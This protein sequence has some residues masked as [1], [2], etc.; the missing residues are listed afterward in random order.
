MKQFRCQIDLPI[1]KEKREREKQAL[2]RLE[3]LVIRTNVDT[4]FPFFRSFVRSFIFFFYFSHCFYEEMKKRKN[5]GNVV[6]TGT[7]RMNRER[8]NNDAIRN[9]IRLKEMKKNKETISFSR[10]TWGRDEHRNHRQPS[11]TASST[12]GVKCL[13]GRQQQ[14]QR[15]RRRRLGFSGATTDSHA[16]LYDALRP[17][18]LI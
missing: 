13:E 5:A 14:Q 4:V 11:S 3:M 1:S 16:P 17:I 15:R 10:S 18:M 6:V 7:E 12:D 9:W 8:N 2:M